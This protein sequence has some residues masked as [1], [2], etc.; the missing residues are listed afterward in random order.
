[1]LL[2]L[3]VGYV[4]QQK[5]GWTRPTSPNAI[6]TPKLNKKT[7]L[8]WFSVQWRKRLSLPEHGA[9]FVHTRDCGRAA[10]MHSRQ[11]SCLR[12]VSRV[13]SSV[14]EWQRA[15]F[16]R[17]KSRTKRDRKQ[18]EGW[19]ADDYYGGPYYVHGSRCSLS[20]INQLSTFMKKWWIIISQAEMRTSPQPVAP[21]LPSYLEDKSCVVVSS[22]AY[23]WRV[24]GI[25]PEASHTIILSFFIIMLAIGQCVVLF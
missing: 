25:C 14:G 2:G 15:I 19:K 1:M 8:V 6:H 4:K 5:K 23:Q 20:L 10:L 9:L 17:T 24:T 3:S 12:T 7:T 18:P 21:C 22:R 11:R 13:E 16:T